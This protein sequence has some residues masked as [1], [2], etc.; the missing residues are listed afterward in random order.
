MDV[1]YLCAEILEAFSSPPV[2]A[3][4][5][6]STTTHISTVST[7]DSQQFSR[8]ITIHHASNISSVKHTTASVINIT[9]P[10]QSKYLCGN[11]TYIIIMI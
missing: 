8:S 7:A 1:L 4:T 3:M 2:P 6:E 10:P 5:T 9:Q 11:Y